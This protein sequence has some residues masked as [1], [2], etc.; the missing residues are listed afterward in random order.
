MTRAKRFVRLLESADS[1][2]SENRLLPF[3]DLGIIDMLD[4]TA[5]LA[6]IAHCSS[7]IPMHCTSNSKGL[8]FKNK[9]RRRLNA[10]NT[11]IN[12]AQT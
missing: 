9:S 7:G 1:M 10:H 5:W 6:F 11:A 4:V 8:L 2:Q 12:A 3:P